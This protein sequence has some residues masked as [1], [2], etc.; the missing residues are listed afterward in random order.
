MKNNHDENIEFLYKCIASLETAEECRNFFED[1]CT[2][3]ELQEISRRLK[4]ARMLSEGVIYA[5]IAAQ[6]GLSTATISRVNHCIK[7]GNEGYLT[8]LKKMKLEEKKH[9]K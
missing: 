5:E 2:R 8:A 6:T 9:S 1:I 7:Y 4:A 3:S